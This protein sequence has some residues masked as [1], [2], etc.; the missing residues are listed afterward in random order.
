[1]RRQTS[2][3]LR[4]IAFFVTL[5][6]LS[7]RPGFADKRVALVIGNGAYQSVPKLPNPPNDAEDIAGTFKRLGY[8]VTPITNASFEEMHRSG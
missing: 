5:I 3:A 6:C 1:V 2:L 7:I 4:A 8:A